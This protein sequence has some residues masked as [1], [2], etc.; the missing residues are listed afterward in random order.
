MYII[1]TEC[2][3]RNVLWTNQRRALTAGDP[4]FAGRN[5]AL[6]KQF[7]RAPSPL[8]IKIKLFSWT[9]NPM[10]AISPLLKIWRIL[11]NFV[12]SGG[13][14]I[15]RRKLK[16]LLIL[17]LQISGLLVVYLFTI[18]IIRQ[19]LRFLYWTKDNIGCKATI[20]V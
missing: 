17:Y 5:L 11:L 10:V 16:S 18:K 1:Y 2:N 15:S 20:F 8:Y 4:N 9:V 12:F 13:I 14:C 19:S 6:K 3:N 7:F